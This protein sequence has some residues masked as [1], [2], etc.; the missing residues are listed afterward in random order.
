MHDSPVLD[1]AYSVQ[2]S[3]WTNRIPAKIFDRLETELICRAIAVLGVYVE[4]TVTVCHA[5]KHLKGVT[6]KGSGGSQ[7]SRENLFGAFV[8][9]FPSDF[10]TILGP[11][12]FSSTNTP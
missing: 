9:N 6:L 1:W 8:V 10:M 11:R 12:L 5:P 7:D 2:F 3:I 4:S